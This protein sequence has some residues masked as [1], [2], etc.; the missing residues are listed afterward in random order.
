MDETLLAIAFVMARRGTCSRAQTG[1]VV[2]LRGR[3]LT[4]GYNGS[5]AGMPHCAHDADDVSTPDDDPDRPTCRVAVHAEANAVAFAAR[6]GVALDGAEL[7][8][9][10]APCVACAQLV[11]NAGIQ[12]V[13]YGRVYRDLAG[14]RLLAEAGVAVLL[15]DA[16]A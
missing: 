2:A 4:T 1:A 3:I 16:G 9:T 6:H 12:R 11:V 5:P 13:V 14:V 8:C 10:L 7:F 15:R